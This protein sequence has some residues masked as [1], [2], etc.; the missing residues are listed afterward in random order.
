MIVRALSVS[1]FRLP[2]R[3]PF[4]T[5]ARLQQWREG[6][7]VELHFDSGDHGIGEASPLPGHG[8]AAG[9]PIAALV[10]CLKAVLPASAASLQDLLAHE[11]ACA[12]RSALAFALETAVLD[13]LARAR[14]VGVASLLGTPR[15]AVP[16]NATIGGLPAP[17]AAKAAGQAVAGGFRTVKLKVG[18]STLQDDVRRVAAV[19]SAIGPD[20]TL[21]LDANGAWNF[22]LAVEA[23]KALAP[24]Q[25]ELLEQPVAAGQ[26]EGWNAL[27]GHGITL[28]A[29]E[30]VATPEAA[31]RVIAAD[32]A[33]LLVLK[34][35]VLG[36]LAVCRD[37][38][39]EARER[40]IGCFVTTTIDAGP[41]TAAT[42][43]LAAALPDDTPA[44][45]LATGT[46][47]VADLLQTPLAVG[48]GVMPLPAEFGLGVTIDQTTLARY[49]F[50]DDIQ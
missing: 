19:R 43:Q 16:V 3:S 47:L 40:G 7:I 8:L 32:A 10:A 27:R 5:A 1:R 41:A 9:P 12:N 44:C 31:R 13:A 22:P 46:L 38:A 11:P 49:A 42:L 20:R 37:I 33:D 25:I 6:W 34:P 18:T 21:R 30:D 50:S 24:Y 28:A 29:D 23:I 35:M 4:A 15:P 48:G 45:G 36:G 17:E 26:I 2:F 14:G 39:I